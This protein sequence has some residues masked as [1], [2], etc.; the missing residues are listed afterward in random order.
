M[1]RK[2]I[3]PITQHYNFINKFSV[4]NKH[5]NT[6]IQSLNKKVETGYFNIRHYLEA[7]NFDQM[8]GKF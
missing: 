1:N 7:Y 5:A 6:L 3:T 4:F 2:L 8:C